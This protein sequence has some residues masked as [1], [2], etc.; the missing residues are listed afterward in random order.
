MPCWYSGFALLPEAAGCI[1]QVN[2]LKWQRIFIPSVDKKATLKDQLFAAFSSRNYRL[3]F[4]G[5]SLSLVGTW[6]QR[7]AVYWL[8]YE[9]SDSALILG[10]TVFCAQFP[11]FVFSVFGGVVSD[12]HNRFRILLATQLASLVQALLLALLVYQGNYELW[13]VLLLTA[14]LGSI[15]AFDV[16]ARQALVY[17]MVDQ[18]EHLSNAIALN[19]SMVNAARLVGPALSGV[20]LDRFGADICFLSNALS[21]VA[22]IISLLLMRLPHFVQRKRTTTVA[23]DLKE[24]FYYLRNTPEISK[25]MLMLAGVSLLSLP[26]ITLLPV[27]AREIYGGDASTFGLLNS[28]VGLG[29]VSGALFLASIRPGA[30][31]KKVLFRCTLLFALG[32]LV[33]SYMRSF[34]IASIFIALAGFG[35]MAQTTVSN[36]LIQTTVA[37]AMRGRVIS[38]YA[39]AF[40]G[41]QP[42]GGLLVG[43]AA[44]VI[45][46]PL[47]VLLQ[48][49]ATLMIGVAFFPFLRKD[50]LMRKQ[51]MKLKQV[52][53]QVIEH[54]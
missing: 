28:F 6:M 49:I 54:T 7:T 50:I 15:N 39:M 12:R 52:E 51:R 45:G 36:T 31:L 26:F 41:M 29:A 5:Q 9:L 17:D 14:A 46:A 43:S 20:V 44:E 18:K 33:F 2:S 35:M 37:P 24:G 10:V 16:P 48:G 8:V 11:S 1:C 32:L 4:F 22:V 3:Y 13:Q 38:Y 42:V 47:T 30:D 40:F 34:P 23:A 19:S 27:Y 25:I 21:F 53:E